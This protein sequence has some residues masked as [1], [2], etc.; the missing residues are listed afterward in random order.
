MFLPLK[1]EDGST[2]VAAADISIQDIAQLLKSN[3]Y[4]T[5]MISLLFLAFVYPLYIAMTRKISDVAKQL[6]QQVVVQNK[7]LIEHAERLTLALQ[8]SKQGWFDIDLKS[9][10]ITVNKEYPE[11]LGYTLDDFPANI[12]VWQDNIHPE[13]KAHVLAEL[14]NCTTTKM[15][16]ELEYRRKTKNGNYLWFHAIARVV[17]RGE[18][19]QPLRLVGIHTDITERKQ[20]E[21]V[22]RTRD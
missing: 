14:E 5:S 4:Q 16:R 3:L 17:E 2:F 8:T 15:A 20:T 12:Q 7:E 9:G 19:D 21:M 10:N 1:A 13:D 18:D 11:L 22:L 6:E